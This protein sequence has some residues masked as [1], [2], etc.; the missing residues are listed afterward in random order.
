MKKFLSFVTILGLAAI[1]N[2]ACGQVTDKLTLAQ[3]EQI[4]LDNPALKSAQLLA[5]ASRQVPGELRASYFPIVQGNI[6]GADAQPGTRLAAGG[7]NNPSVYDRFSN[8]LTATQMLTDF[9]RT[10]HLIQSA[11][12]NAAAESENAQ[13]ARESVI[14]D[15]DHA[16]YDAL[17]AQALLKVA[18][19]AVKTRQLLVDQASAL[20]ESK[21]KSEL[22]LSFAQVAL[23]QAKLTLEKSDNDV[24]AAFAE[25]SAALGYPRMHNFDLTD[26]PTP[27]SPPPVLNELLPQAMQRPDIARQEFKWHAAEKFSTAERDLWFPSISLV[28]TAG[29]T[30]LGNSVF[31]DRYAAAGFNVSVPVFNGVLFKSRQN[32]A[33]LKEQSEH[34]RLLDVENRAVRDLRIAWLDASTAYRRLDLSAQLLDQA[35]KA[36][37]LAQE[38]YKLGLSSIVELSQAQLNQTQAEFDQAAAKYDYLSVFSGLKFQAGLLK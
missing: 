25:L 13:N 36:L 7:L 10:H 2:T 26:E 35:N 4:A 8:G 6:T 38:R 23:S 9:G 5:M 14:L 34:Q 18:Q 24:Q 20:M 17:R 12:L 3:A 16:Y 37:D 27:S 30:P 15:V 21:L 19:E 1:G 28:G 11:E 22:D 31:R 32:E 33:K 29:L